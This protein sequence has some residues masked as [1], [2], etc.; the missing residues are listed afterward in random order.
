MVGSNLL[1]QIHKRLQQITGSTDNT[2]FGNVSI[3]AVGDFYQLQPVGDPFIF[4]QIGDA[5]ARLHQSGS[6]WGEEFS[7]MELTEIMRQKEDAEFAELLCRVRKAKCTEQDIKVLSSRSITDDDPDYPSQSLH[8]YSR[9]ADVDVQNTKMLNQL[10]PEDQQVAIKAIDQAKDTHTSMLD[11]TMPTSKANTGGLVGVLHLAVGAKVIL[12][13]NI[14]V[15]DGLVNGAL[16]TVSGI[17]T[18]GNHVTTI[19][20]FNSDRVGMAAI[21][22]SHYRQD[23][24]DSVPIT[25]PHSELAG[26]RLLRHQEHSSP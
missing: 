23:Y 22:K 21:H 26:P 10:T 4:D 2:T 3:L 24:P 8:V 15:S 13:V 25:R 6:L 18:T 7:M 9:N 5:Y 16:G 11:V 19:L 12:V 14:D 20:K 1:L 17:I